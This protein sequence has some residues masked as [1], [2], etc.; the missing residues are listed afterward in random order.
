M[1]KKF[2]QLTP[3]QRRATLNLSKK[4]QEILENM[5]LDADIAN[6][7]IENQISEFELPMGLARNFV[8]NG[9]TYQVPMVIEEPSVVAAASNGAKIAGEFTAEVIQRLMR[10]QIVFY[11]IQAPEKVL[12]KLEEEEARI[13]QC[14]IEA[15]PSIVKRGGGLRHYGTR[16]F[17]EEKFLSVDFKIDVKDAMGANITN[18]ILEGLSQLFREWFPQEQILFSI[19]S[20]YATESLVKVS[21]DIPVANLSK[22]GKG[23]EV[24][25][26]IVAASRFS[27]LDT[28]RATTHNKGIMNGINAV[29]LATGNDTR[30]I[31]AGIHAYAAK[32]G[33]YQGLGT[34]QTHNDKLHGELIVPLPVATV[35]GGVKVLPK[36]QTALEILDVKEAKI[37]AQ[38][39][40]SVG[41]AQNLAALRA[42]VSEGIQQGHMS[43]QARSLALS[44]GAKGEEVSKITAR[45]RQEKIMNQAVAKNILEELRKN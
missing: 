40:A 20:N 32:D 31:A 23:Q 17:E 19:L 29:V 16:I 12:Q 7:L 35:G 44:V 34:W 25:E 3:A 4:H 37:L 38:I 21:C 36:A 27:K 11:D 42:L 14:A 39:I 1:E 9:H 15:Y 45:L 8:V 26:K 33:S 22:E 2:Y 5:A 13:F 41:L 18:S 24:A 28:Y 10:G 43:L 30:A 6:N